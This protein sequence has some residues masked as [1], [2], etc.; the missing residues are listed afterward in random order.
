[1]KITYRIIS[2][3]V[4]G[5]RFDG[6]RVNDMYRTSYTIDIGEDATDKEIETELKGIE[7]LTT[8]A[9]VWIDGDM[10]IMCVYSNRDGRPL[11]ELHKEV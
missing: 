8:Q 3:D 2:L 10:D 4:W 6:F 5:N 11:L 1:M 7:Y 9:S